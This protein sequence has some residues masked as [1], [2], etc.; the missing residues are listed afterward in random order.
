VEN[1]PPR[2][3][4]TMLLVDDNDD[5][6]VLAKW[7]FDS[8]GYIVDTARSAEE[9]LSRF[10]PRTHDLVLTD[11]S[12]LKMTGAEMSHVVKMRSPSTLV[13]MFTANPPVDRSCIDAMI[14]KPAGLL[15]VKEAMDQLFAKQQSSV[16]ASSQPP[17]AAK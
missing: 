4:K 14:Q 3:I 9:A 11:N 10:D 1:S 6:R 17:K 8:L 15:D 5:V 7:Y 16:L 2:S 13:I 12:M